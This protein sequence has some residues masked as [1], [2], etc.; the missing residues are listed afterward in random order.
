MADVIL[1]GQ[2][3]DEGKGKIVDY[4]AEKYDLVVRQQGGNNAGHTIVVN[5]KKTILHLIPSGILHDNVLCVIGNGVVIDPKVI[6]KEISDLKESG[7]N[8]TSKNLII[9]DRAHIILPYHIA[10]DKARDKNQGIGTTCRGIGPAYS[11]KYTRT[12]IRMHEFVDKEAF[13]QRLLK[14]LEEK[15]FLLTNSENKVE[16]LICLLAR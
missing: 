12:G 7:I 5:N 2:W 15:N 9:S 16:L 10:I 1:G 6:L 4:L 14:V 11:D 8:V 13:K 3:G